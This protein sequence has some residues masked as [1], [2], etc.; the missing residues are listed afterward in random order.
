MKT[1]FLISDKIKSS[2]TCL[3]SG[4]F[5]MKT[6]HLVADRAL[7]PNFTMLD[8]QL[9]KSKSL[10]SFVRLCYLTTLTTWHR[11][12]QIRYLTHRFIKVYDWLEKLL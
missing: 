3:I 7:G 6:K 12:W 10:S 5:R 11:K 8:S 9:G 2:L 4:S 1:S